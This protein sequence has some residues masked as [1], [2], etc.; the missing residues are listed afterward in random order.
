[1]VST[2]HSTYLAIRACQTRLLFSAGEA[3][4]TSAFTAARSRA[5][6]A[7]TANDLSI[8]QTPSPPSLTSQHLG[9]NASGLVISVSDTALSLT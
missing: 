2:D 8:E 5:T 1:M 9:K 4:H 6:A 3:S 7:D